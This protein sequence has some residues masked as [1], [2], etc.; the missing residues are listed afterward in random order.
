MPSNIERRARRKRQTRLVFEPTSSSPAA[1]N[2]LSPAKV[3]YSLRGENAP[4]AVVGDE[5][6][7]ELLIVSSTVS[8]TRSGKALPTPVKSSQI[9]KR[10]DEMV[11]K[12]V[13][14]TKSV[15]YGMSRLL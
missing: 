5:N 10:H 8:K 1:P 12:F 3:R 7:D 15:I 11:G 9:G 14:F 4:A 6:E 2:T 13:Q